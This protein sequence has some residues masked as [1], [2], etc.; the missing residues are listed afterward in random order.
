MS[1]AKRAEELVKEYFKE[2]QKV[3]LVK[4]SKG[5]KGFDFRDKD[6]NIF[7]E[8][9][10]SSASQ[11]AE[12]MFLMFTNAEYEKAKDC[13]RQHTTYEVHLITGVGTDLTKQYVIPGKAFVNSAKPE[14]TWILPTSKKVIRDEFL[15]KKEHEKI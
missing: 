7:V 8:V 13:L 6:S 14:I 1:V 11:L 3:V 15:I 9:K 5:E 4:P 10:G 2:T 12:V